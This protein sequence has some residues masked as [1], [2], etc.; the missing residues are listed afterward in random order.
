LVGWIAQKLKKKDRKFKRDKKLGKK[1]S[2]VK[3]RRTDKSSARGNT[4]LLHSPILFQKQKQ[5][6]VEKKTN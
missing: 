6:K 3:N 5:K 1:Q 2:K 4:D